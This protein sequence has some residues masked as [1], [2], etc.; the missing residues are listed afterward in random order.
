MRIAIIALGTRGDVQPY[1]A[2][3]KGLAAAGH[4]V[5]LVTH[6]NFEVLVVS[7]VNLGTILLGVGSCG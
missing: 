5:R 2:L 1:L 4:E 7:G 3:G 6:E